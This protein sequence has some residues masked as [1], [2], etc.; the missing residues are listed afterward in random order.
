MGELDAVGCR[1]CRQT[2]LGS[3]T[4]WGSTKLYQESVHFTQIVK[5]R[6]EEAD[7]RVAVQV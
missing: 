2:A 1:D 4:T 6:A 3:L 7:R 5:V